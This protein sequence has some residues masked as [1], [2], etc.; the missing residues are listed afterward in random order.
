M[1]ELAAKDA[2]E[3]S[4][5]DPQSI[6]LL[7]T[8]T[9]VPDFLLGNPGCLTHQRLGLA[10]SC[11]TIQT[12]AAAYSFVA[13]LAVANAMI[14]A[15]QAHRALLI[16][17]CV[18]TRLIDPENP[19]SPLVGDGA[20]AIVVGPTHTDSGLKGFA[21]FTDGNYPRT[22]IMSV[23]GR[24]WYS[25][26][27]AWMHVADPAQMAEVFLQTADVCKESVD[28]VLASTG[29]SARDID[30][31][32]VYQGTPW[33]RSVV[34]AYLG[35]EHCRSFETFEQYGY[36]SSAMIPVNLALAS[37]SGALHDGDTVLLTGGGTGMTFGAAI[38][39]WGRG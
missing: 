29:L 13:Q 4:A 39:R 26:G 33:L 25:D 21:H 38:V 17:S 3:D 7:L 15:G 9:V 22:L 8:H 37:R 19:G 32:C 31:L 35:L 6:D 14:R 34:Q 23:P 2:L 18:A 36:L 1:E 30:F 11:M 16:Q 20:S 10:R 24:T 28:A 12:D 5:I 27:A